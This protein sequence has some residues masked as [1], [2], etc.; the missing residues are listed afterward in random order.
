MHVYS[1]PICVEKLLKKQTSREL[2]DCIENFLG[3][4]PAYGLENFL[5]YLYLPD[6]RNYLHCG[7]TIIELKGS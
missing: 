3:R 7:N 4:V 2:S 6:L 1:I 5:M